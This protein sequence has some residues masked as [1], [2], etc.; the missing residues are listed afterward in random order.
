[1]DTDEV[2]HFQS[3]EEALLFE[4]KGKTIKQIVAE[5]DLSLFDVVLNGGS[6]NSSGATKTFK[7]NSANS[8]FGNGNDGG[9]YD[10]DLPARLNTKIKVKTREE[11][12]K[13]FRK[14]HE[15]SDIEHS[16]SIDRNGFVS[17]YTHGDKNSVM[18]P[19]AKR[20]ETIVHNHP[21]RSWGKGSHFSDKDLINTAKSNTRAGIIATFNGG[22]HEFMKG[23][24][25]KGEKFARA[26]K[27]VTLKGKN[28]DYAVDRWLKGNQKKYGYKYEKHL[29]KKAKASVPKIKFDASGQGSLF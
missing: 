25:F 6:G 26:V 8:E 12:I 14:M 2:I 17:G 29:D 27:N 10:T 5:S 19:V 11:A 16:V 1:M 20:G 9:K 4:I 13:Q 7:F 28:Y 18:S 23:T 22:Y 24:H 3:L 15:N 21:E